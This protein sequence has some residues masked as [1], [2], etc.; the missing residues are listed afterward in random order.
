ME[1]RKV[2][3]RLLLL[4]LITIA[5]MVPLFYQNDIEEL[6]S[7]KD[8]E[9]SKEE[10]LRI[11][12]EII[13]KETEAKAMVDTLDSRESD[14]ELI[15]TR[16]KEKIQEINLSDLEFHLPS[17]LIQLDREANVNNL[18]LE[19]NHNHMFVEEY[20]NDKMI[21]ELEEPNIEEGEVEEEQIDEEPVEEPKSNDG[22][23]DIE[24]VDREEEKAKRMVKGDPIVGLNMTIIP[25]KVEGEF[26]NVRK[27]I[28][29]LDTINYIEPSEV[30]I[31]SLGDKVIGDIALTVYHE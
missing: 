30:V 11:N 29:F 10:V 25:I 12:N 20:M 27:F 23:V 21:E 26:V 8:I 5:L 18:E 15:E 22:E 17:I 14:K 3:I 24:V 31:N 7:L 6:T 28:H 13:A 19:I 9:E 1:K 16:A 4:F 2:Q